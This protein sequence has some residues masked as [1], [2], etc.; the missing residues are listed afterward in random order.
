MQTGSR[1]WKTLRILQFGFEQDC[2]R[3]QASRGQESDGDQ[4]LPTAG[5]TRPTEVDR[6]CLADVTDMLFVVDVYLAQS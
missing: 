6:Q 1:G 3:A 4:N 5:N 2:Y